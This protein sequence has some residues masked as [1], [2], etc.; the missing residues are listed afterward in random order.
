MLP[1]PGPSSPT[2][3]LSLADVLAVAEAEEAAF[4]ACPDWPGTGPDP[5]LFILYVTLV[6]I[7]AWPG[8]TQVAIGSVSPGADPGADGGAV[9]LYAAYRPVALIVLG[10]FGIFS[11][12][13]TLIDRMIE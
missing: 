9:L 1:E 13:L 8:A 10:A 12:A 7:E 3:D 5:E 4:L 11:P 6:P 2:L